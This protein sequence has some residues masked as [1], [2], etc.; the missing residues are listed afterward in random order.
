MNYAII[1]SRDF[2]DYKFLSALLDKIPNITKVVSGGARGADSLAERW[3]KEHNIE[4]L[5][6]IP[7]WDQYGKA[8]GFIRNKDIVN[9]A[10]RII[11][12]WDGS[13]KGTK[14]SI[15]YAAKAGKR[16]L[17]VNYLTNEQTVVG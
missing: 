3:A 16:V 9:N 1:G 5:L 2:K 8:A 12:L 6:F 15:D 10:D 4:V 14:S 7:D 13:S 11:A 17:I